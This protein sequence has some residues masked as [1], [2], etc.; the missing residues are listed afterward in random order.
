[1]LSSMKVKASTYN[2]RN[3]GQE[4]NKMDFPNLGKMF[5]QKKITLDHVKSAKA[6][7]IYTSKTVNISSGR[8]ALKMY[9]LQ[10]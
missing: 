3:S 1:M 7:K 8:L 10:L 5:E 9:K 6:Q 4:D 2:S